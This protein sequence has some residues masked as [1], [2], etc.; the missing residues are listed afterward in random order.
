MELTEY[1]NSLFDKEGRRTLRSMLRAILENDPEKPHRIV[2]VGD[3]ANGKTILLHFVRETFKLFGH[4]QLIQ[5]SKL[6]RSQLPYPPI[7][8]EAHALVTEGSPE[9][10][11][12]LLRSPTLKV[13]RLYEN[14]EDIPNSFYILHICTEVPTSLQ[15]AWILRFPHHFISHA[16]FLP[17]LLPLREEFY[18][19]IM[20]E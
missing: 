13:G 14:K 17:Q 19:W 3:G 10:L 7:I 18:H 4:G 2:W 11:Q 1:L 6:S 8:K 5:Y 15:E 9:V 20:K 16:P 12:E